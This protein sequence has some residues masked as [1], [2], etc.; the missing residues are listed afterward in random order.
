MKVFKFKIH[1]PIKGG[2]NSMNINRFGGHYAKHS[3]AEWRD[4]VVAEF[5]EVLNLKELKPVF[6]K[7]CKITVF[8]TPFDRKRRDTPAMLDSI[9]HCLEKVG[10]VADD[11]LLQNVT[12]YQY[13]LDKKNAGEEI[14]VSELE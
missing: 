10:L 7:P 8:Y 5:R 13:A 6:T 2:K 9:Y 12:W 14:E 11:C 4:Q 1:G 3:W